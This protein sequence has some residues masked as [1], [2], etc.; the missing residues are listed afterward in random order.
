MMLKSSASSLL[1]HERHMMTTV[2]IHDV[3]V[4]RH[5][6]WQDL[7]VCKGQM[8]LFF[9]RKAERPQARARREVKA[10]KLCAACPVQTQCLEFSRENR[11][12]GFW[13]GESEEERHLAGYTLTAPIGIK[14]RFAQKDSP[15][16]S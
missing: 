12:Y 13:A 14:A 5:T 10:A 1:R 3:E 16:A 4:D 8:A 2:E 6:D 7:A 9:A 11:E 15:I